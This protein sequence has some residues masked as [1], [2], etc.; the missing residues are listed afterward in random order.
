MEWRK[1]MGAH[2]GSG[3]GRGRLCEGGAWRSR[4]AWVKGYDHCSYGGGTQVAGECMSRGGG[5]GGAQVVD[6]WPTTS[7][8]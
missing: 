7:K 5:G 8:N 1:G 6:G 4:C 2:R 3:C